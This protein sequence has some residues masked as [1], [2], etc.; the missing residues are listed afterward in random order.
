MVVMG[1]GL[2]MDVSDGVVVANANKVKIIFT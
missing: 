1:D 2:V